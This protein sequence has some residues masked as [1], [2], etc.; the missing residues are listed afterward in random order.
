MTRRRPRTG[1]WLAVALTVSLAAACVR[2]E[3]KSPRAGLPPAPWVSRAIPDAKGEIKILSDG[4]KE[5]VRYK[6]WTTEDFSQYRTYAYDD[7][8]AP[9]PIGQ[10][11]MPAV[12][13]NPNTGRSL[14]LNRTLGP[15]T[16]CHLIQGADVWPAGNVGR[17]LS[18]FGDRNAADEYVFSLIY[19]ARQFFPET[20]MPPW[21]SAGVLKPEDIVHLVA[22]LQTQRS[23]ASPEKDAERDPT[24]RPK[25]RGFGDNLDATNNPAVLRAERAEALWATKGMTGKGC[26]DCHAGG[27]LKAMRGVAARYPQYVALYRRVMSIE[28]FLTAHAPENT[29]VPLLAGSPDNVDLT[30]LIKMASNG[31]PVS[32]DLSSAE[33]A[34]ALGRG[35]AT[36]Y[37]KVGQRNHAC[38]DCHTVANGRGGEKFLGGRLL[39]N[40]EAGFTRHFPTWRT[41]QA[42]VWDMRKRMQWCMTP[43]GTNMLAADAV[44]YAELEL[45]LTF[46]DRGKPISV[47][48][49][50]H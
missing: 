21:G 26:A 42:D 48:G 11:A 50:R 2:N 39:G 27:P 7:A 35:K 47:P 19:D 29:G 8:H 22:F 18:T 13:G 14:F 10:A 33:N 6:G 3:T 5:A 43:L 36:F 44:E 32:I 31:M 23:P 16:G 46:F 45:Y 34:A 1:A 12:P 41:S 37:K 20:T 17:D 25:P 9:L 28:D 49:I 30:M 24:T 15:C 40:A 4:K 38:A